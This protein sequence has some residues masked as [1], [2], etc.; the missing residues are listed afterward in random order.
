V[1]LTIIVS[2]FR[3]IRAHKLLCLRAV[4]VG[5]IFLFISSWPVLLLTHPYAHPWLFGT[6]NNWVLGAGL[7]PPTWQGYAM[8]RFGLL[9][10]G[11]IGFAGAGWMVARF[12]RAHRTPMVLAFL[13]S[14]LVASLPYLYLPLVGSFQGRESLEA[15]LINGVLV[16]G[17][18]TASVLL[19]AFW[20][21]QSN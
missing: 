15:L 12:H 6:L 11:Y 3:E 8:N 17:G 19:G 16:F 5:G 4:T 9:V 10:F 2:S 13:A 21:N 20:T 18:R 7:I 14:V 1:L